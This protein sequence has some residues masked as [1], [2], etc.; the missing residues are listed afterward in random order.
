MPPPRQG[1]LY[2]VAGADESP[3]FLRHNLLIQ[4]AWGEKAVPL[5]EALLGL[6]HF[7][8]VEALAQ[9]GHRLHGHALRLLGL[10]SKAGAE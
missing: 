2:T 4:Q 6:N 10:A 3:E 7:S 1:E 8:I 9:P 5:C